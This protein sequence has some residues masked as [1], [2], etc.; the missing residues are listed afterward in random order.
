M[1]RATAVALASVSGFP[2]P[3]DLAQ[4]DTENRAGRES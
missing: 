3:E 2:V 4:V 1:A